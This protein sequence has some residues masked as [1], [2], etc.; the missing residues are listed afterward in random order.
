MND[1]DLITPEF[2]DSLI[3]SNMLTSRPYQINTGIFANS[4]TSNTVTWHTSTRGQEWIDDFPEWDTIQEMT[5]VYPA[6]ENAL[7]NL[8]T[9]YALVKDDYEARKKIK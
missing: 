6:M 1:Q 3:S 5:K 9:T 7:K 8:Q 4:I 2:V